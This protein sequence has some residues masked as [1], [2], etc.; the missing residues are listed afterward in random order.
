MIKTYYR[1][2]KPGIVYGNVFTTLAA[3]L[4]ASRWHVV[5]LLF[6]ATLI[7]LGLVI[8][9]ACVFNNYL[10]RD[11]DRKMA[12]TKDRTLVTGGVSPHNALAYGTLLGLIGFSSSRAM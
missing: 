7:G 9:S 6:F 1:L 11:I 4:F 3:Y 8:A 2:T 5:P 12:R 10:D